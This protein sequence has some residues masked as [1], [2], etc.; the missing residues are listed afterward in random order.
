MNQNW[1]GYYAGFISRMLAFFLD[2][3]IIA[4]T[5]VSFTWFLSVTLTTLQVRNILA[6]FPSVYQ[7]LDTLFGPVTGAIVFPLFILAY[8]VLFLTFVGQTPGKALIGLRV[9]R[10]SGKR[11]SYLHS[12]IRTLAYILSA[13]PFGL[14]FIWVLFD[15][16]RQAWHDKL[17]GSLVIYTWEARPDE[18]FLAGLI[19][20]LT[21]EETDRPKLPPGSDQSQS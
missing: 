16:K 2:E 18:R 3:L 13:L 21:Q 17:V 1:K 4:V 20:Q 19:N 15:E 5:A 11:L 12:L 10:R 6:N 8:H 7:V 14:G 9:V